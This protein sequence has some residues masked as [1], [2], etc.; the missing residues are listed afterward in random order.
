MCQGRVDF[1]L[2][3]FYRLIFLKNELRCRLWGISWVKCERSSLL[4]G[5]GVVL[6]IPLVVDRRIIIN[7]AGMNNFFDIFSV[8]MSALTERLEHGTLILS[9]RIAEHTMN[10]SAADIYPSALYEVLPGMVFIVEVVNLDFTYCSPAFSAALG[11]ESEHFLAH[12]MRL[13]LSLMHTEDVER[14]VIQQIRELE[15]EKSGGE[16]HEDE[17]RLRTSDG[18]WKWVLSRRVVFERHA[19]GRVKSILNLLVNITKN[20]LIEGK[21]NRLIERIHEQKLLLS[22]SEELRQLLEKENAQKQQQIYRLK[23]EQFEIEAEYKRKELVSTALALAEKNELLTEFAGDLEK[24][25]HATPTAA[26]AMLNDLIRRVRQ[27]HRSE[28]AWDTFNEQ[29]LTLHNDFMKAISLRYPDLTPMEVK[30]C[31]LLK[32]N[33]ST[34]EIA[35]I[36]Q[37]SDR[38][39]DNHRYRLRKKLGLRSDDNLTVFLT[40]L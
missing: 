12:G 27:A 36:L 22:K 21:N 29:F 32:L 23:A 2:L 33:L 5:M 34:K 31:T 7:L 18:G 39:I 38:N 8:W 15:S 30:V 11:V 1:H 35:R 20:K 4:R 16:V 14:F 3:I 13:F 24:L 19:D 6:V 17:F 28:S 25:S 9:P 40:G 37:L 10:R 26:K